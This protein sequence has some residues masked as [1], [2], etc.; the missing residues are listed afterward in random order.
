[1][2][3]LDGSVVYLKP[4]LFHLERLGGLY[5]IEHQL[6]LLDAP[7]RVFDRDCLT[8]NQVLLRG[9]THSTSTPCAARRSLFLRKYRKA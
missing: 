4:G 5:D 2:E 9:D 1:M 3:E 6:D 7:Q 8:Q